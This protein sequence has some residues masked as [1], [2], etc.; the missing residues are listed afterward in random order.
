MHMR[1][2]GNMGSCGMHS[3]AF[4]IWEHFKALGFRMKRRKL[5]PDLHEHIYVVALRGRGKV[6]TGECRSGEEY[7]MIWFFVYVSTEVYPL[8]TFYNVFFRR[9][10]IRPAQLCKTA[11]VR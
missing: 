6:M 2:D 10:C 11:L 3:T 7:L 5:G 8:M 4:G 9:W 1:A